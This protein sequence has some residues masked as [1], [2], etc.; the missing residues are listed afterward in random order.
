MKKLAFLFVLGLLAIV[1]V[2]GCGGPKDEPIVEEPT[3]PPPPPVDTTPEPPPPPPPPPELKESQLATVYFD[4]DKFNLRADA[5]SGLDQNYGLLTEFP[6][7]IIQIE[8]HC[9]ERGTIEYNMS[10]GDKR[11]N[12]ARDYLMGLGIAETR[13]STISY[14][15]E[16]A[17]ASGS[18]ED[19]W[20][21]NRRCEFKI[22]SQ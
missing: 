16:R 19:A 2:A 14:G 18:G 4:F 1:L 22:V 21:Q 11:A 7:V 17:A 10:L 5:K 8:G 15:E 6:D 13:L 20:A 12:A 3:P 9:D